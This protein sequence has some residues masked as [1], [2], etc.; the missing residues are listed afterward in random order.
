[1]NNYQLIRP[2]LCKIRDTKET[3]LGFRPV[4]SIKSPDGKIKSEKKQ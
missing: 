4:P 1:M 2:T 3:G